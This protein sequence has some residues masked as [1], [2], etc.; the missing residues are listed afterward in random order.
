MTN[1]DFKAHL[2][3]QMRFLDASSAAFDAD[4]HDEAIRIAT[5]IRVL[6][7]QTKSST[8]LLKHLNA[9][10]INLLS[11]CDGATE[12]TLMYMSMGTV[13]ISGDGT[14]KYLPSLGDGRVKNLIPMSKW[15]DQVVFVEGTTRLSRKKIVLSA[16]NQDGGSHVDES[17]NSDYQAL[18]A[19]GFAGTVFH[20]IGGRTTEQPLVGTHF[21]A[22]RQMA[23][24]LLNSPEL[25]VAAA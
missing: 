13:Q 15:W 7:H 21:V 23:F 14:H 10:T 17:L 19:D 18:T 2:R 25:L 22:L 4:F 1:P 3:R 12:K 24:E 8:S 16:A 9:T 11:T 6:V 5:I 20:S